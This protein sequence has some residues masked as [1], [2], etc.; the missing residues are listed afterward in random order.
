MV[1]Y[2]KTGD[3]PVVDDCQVDLL[4]DAFRHRCGLFDGDFPKTNNFLFAVDVFGEGGRNEFMGD[5]DASGFI[6]FDFFL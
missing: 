1:I 4:P 6:V 5:G 3:F 2:L